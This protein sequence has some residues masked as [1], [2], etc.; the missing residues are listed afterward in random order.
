MAQ[1]YS[2]E[3]WKEEDRFGV[4]TVHKG[5][6]PK[7]AE[8]ISALL[9]DERWREGKERAQKRFAKVIKKAVSQHWEDA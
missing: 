9:Q 7:Q 3:D 4:V 1:D 8:V 2:D 6:G 5:T